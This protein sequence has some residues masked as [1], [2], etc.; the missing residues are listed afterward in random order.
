MYKIF[1][2]HKKHLM[3][4]QKSHKHHLLAE[5]DQIKSINNKENIY[6]FFIINDTIY[7]FDNVK[8]YI[9]LFIQHFIKMISFDKINH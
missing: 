4:K 2:V 3:K 1:N 5:T 8:M 6:D 7:N 9:I